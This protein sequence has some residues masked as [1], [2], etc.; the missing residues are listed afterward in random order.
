MKKYVYSL[1]LVSLCLMLFATFGWT[2]VVNK[3]VAIVN[4]EIISMKEF[5]KEINPMLEQYSKTITGENKEQK[6]EE[7]KKEMLNQLIDKKI[8]IQEVE[9]QKIKVTEIDIEEGIKEIRKNFSSEESFNEEFKK[10]NMD[11]K[12]FRKN[13]EESLLINKLIEQEVKTKVPPPTD[14]AINNYYQ[15]HKKNFDRPEQFWAKHILIRITKDADFKEKSRALNSIRDIERQLKEGADFAELAKKYSED[16]GSRDK[17]GDLGFVAKGLMVKEFEEAAFKLKKGEV[18]GIVETAFGYHIIKLEDKKPAKQ[19]ELED[20][21]E[22]GGQLI[23]VKDFIK[24]TILGDTLNNKFSE[25][26]KNLRDTAK[27][28]IKEIK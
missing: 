16:P 27:I 5:E 25:W 2:K 12:E 20:E 8:L 3:P 11:E 6:I 28:E 18:S 26:L 10:Q 4:G 15:E 14:E 9:K 17:G 13:V 19:L 23:K 7:F 21:L 1:V 24:E 22:I